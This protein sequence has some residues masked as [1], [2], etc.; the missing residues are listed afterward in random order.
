DD[1]LVSF[2]GRYMSSVNQYKNILGVH[3]RG[4]RVPLEFRR[5]GARKE[6]LVRL[7][8]VQAK[9][10]ID[11]TSKEKPDAPPPQ[12][13]KPPPKLQPKGPPSPLAKYYQP[14]PGFAN[15]YFNGIQ[16]DRLMNEFA[17]NGDFKTV[18][19]H[20]TLDGEV[21]FK[22]ARTGSPVRID[23]GEEKSADGKSTEPVVRMKVGEIP[24][25]LY[26]LKPNQDAALL[27]NPE[28]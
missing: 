8:G 11:P 9:E 6:I 22:K 16:R 1:E 13:G 24:Y 12:P 20:W 14:K 3:P 5:E 17:K 21:T 27:K 4:W 18:A 19:G 7:M 28:P 25:V 23:I 2:A 15:A 10:L 26:P